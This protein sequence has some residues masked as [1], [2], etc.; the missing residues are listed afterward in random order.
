[1]TKE[2]MR[3][4]FKQYSDADEYLKFDRVTISRMSNRPDLNAFMLLADL[5]ADFNTGTQNIIADA[6]HDEITLN[7]DPDDLARVATPHVI[8][9][10][11]RCGVRY[12]YN[13]EAFEMF[14]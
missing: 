12:N 3:D 11:V 6:R 4:L 8:L 10:L 14:A 9:T 13:D 1:M 7:V 2:E 5:L